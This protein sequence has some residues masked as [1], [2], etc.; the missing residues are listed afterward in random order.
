LLGGYLFATIFARI[1]YGRAL[2][3]RERAAI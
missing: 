3:E 2:A 1:G